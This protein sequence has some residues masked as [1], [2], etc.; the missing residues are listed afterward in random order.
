MV[1]EEIH[2]FILLVPATASFSNTRYVFCRDKESATYVTVIQPLY[3]YKNT[4]YF[5]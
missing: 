5:Q 4:Y 1:A 2:N 3:S